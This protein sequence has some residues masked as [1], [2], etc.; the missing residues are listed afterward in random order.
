[1][2]GW[3]KRP[4]A[5]S[6]LDVSVSGSSSPSKK[7]GRSTREEN[8]EVSLVGKVQNSDS[9]VVV[10]L[11]GINL[12]E[13]D[14]V[15]AGKS[16]YVF[17][18]Q[19]NQWLTFQPLPEP[20]HYHAVVYYAGCIYVFGGYSPADV[21]KGEARAQRSVFKFHVREKRWDKAADMLHPR[22]CHGAAVV[23]EKIMVVGGKDDKGEIL[24][25]V[26]L[27][28]PAS[29]SWVPYRSL[30]LPIMGCGVGY[31]AGLVYVVG[32]VTT[33]RQ[34]FAGM[35]PAEVLSTVH[36][37]DPNERTWLRRPSL[38]EPRAYCTALTI[39]HELW[40]AG[41]LKPSG[42]DP[43]GFTNV[44]DVLAFDSLRGRWEFRFKLSRPRHAV[45]A[46][47]ADDR[48]YVVGGMTCLDGTSV[49]DVDVYHRQRLGFLDC[50]CL[51]KKLTGL[52]AVTVPPE[53]TEGS[54]P[55]SGASSRAPSSLKL[56]QGDQDKRRRPHKPPKS[57]YA[58]KDRS[59]EEI[60]VPPE[61]RKK[62]TPHPRPR[63]DAGDVDDN[64]EGGH[65]PPSRLAVDSSTFLGVEAWKLRT[66]L[67]RPSLPRF[68]HYVPAAPT[69]DPHHGITV[70]VDDDF[71]RTKEM[72]GLRDASGLPAF[73]RKLRRVK[74][75]QDD[76][77]PVILTFGGLDPRDP[78]NYAN[79]RVVLH[80]H[81]LKNR[82]DLCGMM[83]EPRSYHA[84]VLIGKVVYVTGGFDPETR[85]SGELVACKTTFAYDID[86]MEWSR[87]ADMK[88]GRAAHGAACFQDKLYVFGGRGR[89]G[90]AVASTEEYD[91]A[92]DTWREGTPLDVPRMAVGCATVGDVIYVVGGMVPES[93]ELYRAVD[94]VDIYDPKTHTWS[95]GHSLPKPRAFP[96]VASLG[97]KLWLVGGCYDNSEPGL[98]LV[99]LRDV[100]VLEPSGWVHVGCTVHSRHA[101]AVAVADTNIYVIGGTSSV[102]NGPIKRPEVY[103]QLNDSYK[104][105]A[106]YPEAMT[107]ISAVCVPPATH[108]FRSQ[109][110]TCMITDTLAE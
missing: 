43:A 8:Q 107:G 88:M 99:S 110:L 18:P 31:L 72:L 45:A 39:H 77:L 2:L 74:K 67:S 73:A 63:T 23:H 96:A 71:K 84:A 20:R 79:G 65:W 56:D 86:A 64:A 32:G 25:S 54:G 48:V 53:S 55:K 13:P 52:A 76:T 108:T 5:A 95:E 14:D 66:P 62:S 102:L 27:Y 24:N 34:V 30:P 10:V 75:V 15:S 19:L 6:A 11:G 49:E 41:G 21:S 37:T 16:T 22:A 80:Y 58:D 46:A 50:Q 47:N 105:P 70:R 12:Q 98:S 101:A 87:K 42:R 109:S 35:V 38:P 36:T 85:K 40:L 59:T 82:W 83:P 97:E 69:N 51:P 93:D 17:K 28:N 44:V 81:V 3:G 4:T 26:E 94:R 100:D 9:A 57:L 78:L 68:Y 61:V 7:D 89:F 60:E 103:L 104:F 29:D 1:M 33:K 106:E 91:P 90:R 92:S